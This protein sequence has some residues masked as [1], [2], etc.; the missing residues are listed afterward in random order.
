MTTACHRSTTLSGC[1]CSLLQ[2]AIHLGPALRVQAYRFYRKNTMLCQRPNSLNNYAD[3]PYVHSDQ[4]NYRPD[5]GKLPCWERMAKAACGDPIIH[6][7]C[8][9]PKAVPWC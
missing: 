8:P 3:E 6:C 1:Y 9:H 4:Y 7:H 2:A 5:N